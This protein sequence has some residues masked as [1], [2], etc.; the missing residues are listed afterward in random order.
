MKYLNDRYTSVYQYEGYDICT[1]STARPSV[2]D[3][4]MYVVDDEFFD[5]KKIWRHSRSY[6]GN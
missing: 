4:L 5:G 1:L 2:G 3:S 6:C